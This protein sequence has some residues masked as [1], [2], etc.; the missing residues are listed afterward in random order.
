VVRE[1]VS[2]G[3]SDEEIEKVLGL[4]LLRIYRGVWGK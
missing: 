4:N 3:Y 2:R 1:M